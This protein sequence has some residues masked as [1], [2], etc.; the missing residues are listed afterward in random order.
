MGKTFSKGNAVTWNT[1]QGTTEGKVVRKVT[2]TTRI[3]G[4][5]AKATQEDPQY[6]VKSDKTGKTAVHRPEALDRA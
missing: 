6:V 4:H 5:T 3:A 2:S 1:P